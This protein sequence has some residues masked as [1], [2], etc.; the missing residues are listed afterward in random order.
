LS[1]TSVIGVSHHTC[2]VEIREKFALTNASP[3]VL[4][5]EYTEES[6]WLSTCNRTELYSIA[7][8]VRLAE[9]AFI[10]TLQIPRDYA[11]NYSYTLRNE[12]AVN[13]LFRVASGLDSAVVGEHEI[14]GQVRRAL[15][16]AQENSSAGPLL[17]RMFQDALAVG[18]R[19]RTE[20]EIGRSPVSVSSAAVSILLERGGWKNLENLSIL[21]IGAGEMALSVARCLQGMNIGDLAISSRTQ[22]RANEIALK[23]GA[24]TLKWP[25]T[26]QRLAQFDAIIS[27]TSSP[28]FLLNQ[29]T[30]EE[31]AQ[32]LSS[33]KL[34]HLMDLAVPRDIDPNVDKIPGV[35]LGNID[36]A[37]T[38][39]DSSLSK[40][41]QQVDP[42]ELII[43]E[44][45]ASFQ[46]WDGARSASE[47]IRLLKERANAIRQSE[48]AWAMPK[49]TGLSP[50]ERAVIE[51]FSARLVNKLLHTPTRRLRETAGLEESASLARL[52]RQVFDLEDTVNSERPDAE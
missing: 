29:E 14:L 3:C 20:T 27:C 18:K 51:R 15:A 35:C 39:V 41:A 44:Q 36:D 33:G 23:T 42:A 7:D 8:E 28:S 43:Q 49:L 24:D 16:D 34:M 26:G 9:A 22:Q 25:V 13:H 46:D 5:D 10:E 40:R 32:H 4:I 37:R 50:D 45:L 6:V 19:V 30:I 48:L 1:I 47:S 12:A 21:I 38:V 2:P 11:E 31:A 52:V 17:T